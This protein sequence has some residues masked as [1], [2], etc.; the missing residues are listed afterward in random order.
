[1]SKKQEIQVF[2][3]FLKSKDIYT[4]YVKNIT[5]PKYFTHVGFILKRNDYKTSHMF[6]KS[7]PPKDF[8]INSFDWLSTEETKIWSELHK[9]WICLLNTAKND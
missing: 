9:E 1:M 7:V 6:L 4:K 8:L 5:N 2:F 3:R